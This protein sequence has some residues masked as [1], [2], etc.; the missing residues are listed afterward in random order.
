MKNIRKTKSLHHIVIENCSLATRLEYNPSTKH[1]G[2]FTSMRTQ[3]REYMQ[4]YH[5][6]N[7]KILS[8]RG[9]VW[10]K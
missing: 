10:A 6:D 1:V 5:V 7:K 8:E 3:R 9:Q 4:Q 2:I